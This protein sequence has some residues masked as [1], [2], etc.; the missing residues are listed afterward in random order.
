MWPIRCFWTSRG[1]IEEQGVSRKVVADMFGM[2]FC[3]Y[4]KKV[5][6]LAEGSTASHRTLWEAVLG[7]LG[8]HGTVSR[9]QLLR[10]F[11]ADG[12]ENVAAVLNDLVESGG[13]TLGF[14]VYPGH[15]HEQQ[16]YALLRTVRR[17]VNQLWSQVAEYN[18]EHP[19]PEAQKRK[20]Y[21]YFGQ[22]VQDNSDVA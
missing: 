8:A 2:A 10:R 15:R 3:T 7:Y 6:R 17:D 11:G 9:T 16:V 1:A 21:F 20:V 14:D 4:Q 18:R 19:V 22:T 5:Q 13:A 12:E